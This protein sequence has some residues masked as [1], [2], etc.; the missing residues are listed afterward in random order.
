MNYGSESSVTIGGD[1][2]ESD[3]SV[4]AW[5]QKGFVSSRPVYL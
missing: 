1:F 3:V 4:L 2:V 5:V